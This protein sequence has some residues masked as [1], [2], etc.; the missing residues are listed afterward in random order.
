MKSLIFT[1]L[2][3]V[4]TFSFGQKMKLDPKMIEMGWSFVSPFV[5]KKIEDPLTK[6]IIAKTIPKIIREDIKGAVYEIS[7]AVFRIKNVKVLNKEFLL[8]AENKLTVA[9]KAVRQKDYAKAVNEMAAVVVITD[10]YIKN[11][12]LDKEVE[13][14]SGIDTNVESRLVKNEEINGKV[15]IE[16][17]SS[18]YFFVSNGTVSEQETGDSTLTT[19]MYNSSAGRKFEMGI[20]K[21][22]MDD[23]SL[24]IDNLEKNPPVREQ[25]TSLMSKIVLKEKFGEGIASP[26]S[27]ITTPNFRAYKLPYLASADASMTTSFITFHNS[28]VFLIYF[29]SSQSDFTANYKEFE[30]LTNMFFFGES[31]PFCEIKKMGKIIV[32][33]KSINP[34]DLFKNGV[35]VATIQGKSE[36]KMNEKLG[37]T[38]LRAVQKSGHMLYPTE[39][40]RTVMIK[41]PCEN[42]T[43]EIGFEDKK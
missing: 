17:N 27:L 39:N 19:F 8:I 16:K 41:S 40:N 2:T 25:F 7:D 14:P 33:N 30:E 37:V 20:V 13:K 6:E 24:S 28:N 32:V 5:I 15:F 21:V 18:Y 1:I 42:G 12:L 38:Y 4:S 29:K 34:Y 35:F 43:V 31:L 10:K 9:Y 26:A 3:I 36:F 11:G 22:E 23:E